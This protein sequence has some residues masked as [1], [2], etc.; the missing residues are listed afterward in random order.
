MGI[1]GKLVHASTQMGTGE[2]DLL[3][4]FPMA[5]GQIMICSR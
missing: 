4:L 3:D 2:S 1:V 5:L